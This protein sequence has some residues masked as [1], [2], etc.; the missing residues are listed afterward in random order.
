MNLALILLPS[1]IVSDA[2]TR[3]MF[4]VQGRE[5]LWWDPNPN[6]RR[7]LNRLRPMKEREAA[8]F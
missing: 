4:K 1:G 3:A 6:P 2:T 8:S 5:V 7:T